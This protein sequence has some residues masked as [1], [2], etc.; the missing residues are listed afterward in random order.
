MG[1]TRTESVEPSGFKALATLPD[2]AGAERPAL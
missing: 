1:P 2:A